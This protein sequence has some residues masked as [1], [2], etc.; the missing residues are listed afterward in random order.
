MA[1]IHLRQFVEFLM[2]LA[3]AEITRLFSTLNFDD[4]DYCPK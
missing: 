1:P 4:R 3:K 2:L